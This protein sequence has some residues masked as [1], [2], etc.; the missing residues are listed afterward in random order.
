MYLKLF[1]QS[2]LA[3]SAVSSA[4][5]KREDT[6]FVCGTRTDDGYM[7]RTKVLAARE[8]EVAES[9]NLTARALTVRVYFHVVASSTTVADGYV[10]DK[11]LSDQF[12]VL[13]KDFGSRGISF[14]LAGTDRTVNAN[15]ANNLDDMAMKRALRKGTYADLNVY[16]QRS[17]GQVDGGTLFGYAHM[18]QPGITSNDDLYWLDG[19]NVL[20]RSMPGGTA[21]PWN[22]GRTATHEVGHWM[23][24]LHT[25]EGGCTGNGDFISDTPAEA[26]ASDGCP[27]G[28]D[29]CPG[30]PGVDP[31]HNFMD[32]S[33]DSCMTEFTVGQQTRMNSAWNSYRLGR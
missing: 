32:Y 2:A 16:F 3:V 5:I 7:Q 25:F 18:P 9:G 21:A 27:T 14:S 1:L 20:S 12:D 10:T 13:Q 26:S 11:M 28:K 22:L 8:L 24:L 23:N 29:T 19:V 6:A 17:L 30:Q 31:I 33:Q 4:H 15:W